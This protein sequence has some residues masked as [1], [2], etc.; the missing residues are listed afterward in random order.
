ML[1]HLNV[2]KDVNQGINLMKY[3]VNHYKN[4]NNPY[5]A[6]LIAFLHFFVMILVEVNVIYVLVSI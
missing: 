3:V 1:M 4:F 2:E 5:G 6:F